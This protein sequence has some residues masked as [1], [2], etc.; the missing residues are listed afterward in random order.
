MSVYSDREYRKR[1]AALKRKTKREN[2]PCWLC[3]REFDWSITDYQAPRAFT[4]DHLEPLARGGRLLGELRPAHRGCNSRRG[5]GRE[6][7]NELKGFETL[8]DW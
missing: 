3:G 2:W 4:A 1:T 7:K 5:D 6:R 8:V